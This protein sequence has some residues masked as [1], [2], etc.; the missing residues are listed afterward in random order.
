MGDVVCPKCH[1]CSTTLVTEVRDYRGWRYFCAV[2]AH[3]W[4]VEVSERT[5]QKRDTMTV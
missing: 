4:P 5:S 1:E 3:D 2:C